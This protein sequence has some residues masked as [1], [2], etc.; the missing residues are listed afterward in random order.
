MNPPVSG[1]DAPRTIAPTDLK[2]ALGRPFG[3]GAE[4]ALLDVREEAEFA[5]GHLFRASSLPLS[6]FELHID[7]LVP[8]RGTP[9]VVCDGGEG[10]AE[11][12]ARRLAGFGYGDAAVLAGGV[13]ALIGQ[14]VVGRPMVGVAVGISMWLAISASTTLGVS[15][16]FLFRRIGVDPAIASGPIITT[17]NDLIASAI[18]LSIATALL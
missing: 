8:R 6:R 5:K 4:L 12:A 1:N 15:L 3:E 10:L 13:A 16:P 2:A 18:Y 9:I 14:V 11:T 7:G 17:S